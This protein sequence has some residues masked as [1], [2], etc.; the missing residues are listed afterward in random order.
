MKIGGYDRYASYKGLNER[1]RELENAGFD[2]LGIDETRNDAFIRASVLAQNTNRAEIMTG[3]AIAFA[4]NPMTLAYTAHDLQV[5]SNGRLILG[6]GS[7]VK[8]HI[9]RRFSM[10]WSHPARRMQEFIQALHAIWDAWEKGIP[11]KFE[12]EFYRHTLMT[13]V[14][15]PE[16][17]APRPKVHLAAVGPLMTNIAASYADGMI[18]HSFTT[19]DYIR[20]VTIP[21][22]ES[23]LLSQGRSREAFERLCCKNREA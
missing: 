14:F 9:E 19:S 13:P 21:Q 1:A 6:L 23:G 8:P 16:D 22:I 3:V 2:T 20:D 17:Q 15:T 7:Q 4:R 10:P 12:G 18:F 5:I 11:L